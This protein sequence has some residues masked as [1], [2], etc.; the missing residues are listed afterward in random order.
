MKTLDQAIRAIVA[1]RDERDWAQFHTPTKL[2]AALA[3]E[4]AEVQETMLWMDADEVQK[5][6]NSD[7]GRATLAHELG[8]VLIFTLLLCHTAGIDPLSAIEKKLAENA[9]K[10][11]VDLAKGSAVKYDRLRGKE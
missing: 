7:D 10:Y 5:H 9:K 4:A 2:A 1:F 11:P 3:I 6:L 8:D